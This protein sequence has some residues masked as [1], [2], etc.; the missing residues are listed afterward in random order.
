MKQHF[1]SPSYYYY[2]PVSD[3]NINILYSWHYKIDFRH[4]NKEK[5]VSLTQSS[6]CSTLLVQWNLW[7]P[8]TTGANEIG[9]FSERYIWYQ[10]TRR[11][12]WFTNTFFFI[13]VTEIYLVVPG[14]QIH[15]VSVHQKSWLVYQHVFLYYSDGNLPCSAR[16]PDTSGVS[17][18]EELSGLP[19]CW[20]LE[21]NNNKKVKWKCCSIVC[22]PSVS[23]RAQHRFVK[24]I[25]TKGENDVIK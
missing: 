5:H 19:T 8:I 21:N 9:W 12:D 2:F 16:I 17:I 7:K 3:S 4:C 23:P 11:V 10:Y 13:T 6:T 24:D 1:H 14:Y 22:H 25:E 18:P 20:R 15:L